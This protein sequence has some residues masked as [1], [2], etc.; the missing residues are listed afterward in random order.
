MVV[1]HIAQ[2]LS[3]DVAPAPGNVPGNSLVEEH[4]VPPGLLWDH[5]LQVTKDLSEKLKFAPEFCDK[6]ED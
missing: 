4:L 3:D 6:S 2:L 5:V 1:D